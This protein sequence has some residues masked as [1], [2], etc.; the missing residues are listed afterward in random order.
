[1]HV[2]HLV[3]AAAVCCAN[4]ASAQDIPFLTGVCAKGDSLL[5]VSAVEEHP[6]RAPSISSGVRIPPFPA[7]L[8]T[9]PAHPLTVVVAF[10]VS[11]N[12]TVPANSVA[13]MSSADTLLSHWACEA[14]PTL[15][16]V[17]ARRGRR[18]VATQVSMPF[19]YRVA[20]PDTAGTMP[21]GRR[22]NEEL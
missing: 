19:T 2:K 1:M 21:S 12:G 13:V 8:H 5:D 20:P 11:M 16:F 7:E 9:D 15:R 18:A 3:L 6:D 14:V 22:S 10:V 17:P 4:A